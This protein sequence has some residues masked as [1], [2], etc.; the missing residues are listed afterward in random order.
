MRMMPSLHVVCRH[1]KTTSAP[2]RKGL[3]L[4]ASGNVG[5]AYMP[6]FGM[7][8]AIPTLRMPSLRIVRRHHKKTSAPPGKGSCLAESSNA[9]PGKGL[10]LAASGNAGGAYMPN[11]RNAGGAYMPSF[12]M[13]AVIPTRG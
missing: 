6:S 8:A 9:P 1:H 11:A 3:Y 4:A 2:P 7:C 13:C 10:Y 12:G 5:G